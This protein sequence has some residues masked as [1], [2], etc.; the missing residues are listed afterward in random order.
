MRTSDYQKACPQYW[1]T[2]VGQGLLIECERRAMHSGWHSNHEH[3]IQ[4]SG[5]LTQAERE[6]ANLLLA[7]EATR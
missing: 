5:R 7:R 1:P 6:Q 2:G 4:W 3:H